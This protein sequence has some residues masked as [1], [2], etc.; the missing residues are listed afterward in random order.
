M[1]TRANWAMTTVMA[2][3]ATLSMPAAAYVRNLTSTGV[4]TSW[5]T[6][7][8]TMEFSLGAPPAELDAV[9]YLDAATQAGA[10]WS[11]AA[12]DGVSRCTNVIFTVESVPDVAGPVG[13][14]YHNR[15]I[16]RQDI[17]CSDP[18]PVFGPCYDPSAL[19]ITSVFQLKTTGEIL[20][21]DIEVNAT[22]FTWGDFVAHPEQFEANTQDFQGALTH[23]FGHAIGLA[24]SCF[25]P[26]LNSDGTL[27]ARP[28]DNLGNPVPG[29]NASD[30]P[31]IVTQ[32]T[33]YGSVATPSAEVELRS[34]S[35]DD[36]QAACDIYAF[37]TNF[38]CLAPS[39]IETEVD[40]GV[41]DAGPIPANRHA[42][43]CAYGQGIE[44]SR[45]SIVALLIL[46]VLHMRVRRPRAVA[47]S[48]WTRRLRAQPASAAFKRAATTIPSPT[49]KASITVSKLPCPKPL[50][51]GSETG[52]NCPFR[53]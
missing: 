39:I 48:G 46:S 23:E 40:A 27:V 43:S 29:C 35:P 53:G 1:R 14:D 33:M 7:C 30:L 41:T 17:W 44:H 36:T 50:A 32:A 28:T 16:F 38:V 31:A 12:L 51:D 4:P 20:D 11:R 45:G 8:V 26:G 6:P 3:V 10:A 5:K 52:Q 15:L 21:A 13:M 47:V 42:S 18:L 2:G 22:N 24:D 19:L 37:T 34:L 49:T 25:R 9:G